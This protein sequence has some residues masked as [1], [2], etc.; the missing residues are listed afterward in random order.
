MDGLVRGTVAFVLTIAA[1]VIARMIVLS[2]AAIVSVTPFNGAIGAAPDEHVSITFANPM[3]R[4]SL[5]NSTCQL[6]MENGQVVP[7][8]VS[9]NAI[10]QTV[11][12]DATQ[13]LQYGAM[14]AVRVVGGGE[15]VKSKYF[16]RELGGDYTFGF[17]TAASPLSGP[18]GPI[19]VIGNSANPFSTYVPEI[20]R[21]EGLNEFGTADSWAITPELLSKYKLV[22]IGDTGINAEQV[23][24]LRGFAL[25]GGKLI[26]LRP[27]QRLAS[28]LGLEPGGEPI[29]DGYLKIDHNTPVGVGLTNTTIQYHGAADLYSLNGATALAWIYSSSQ[30]ATNWPA[31]TI[32]N[33]GTHGGE[34]A[35]FTFDLARAIVYTR[36]G[37]PAWSGVHRDDQKVGRS[38]DQLL[39]PAKPPWV[40]LAK[41]AVPQADEQQSLFANLIEQMMLPDAPLPRFWYFPSG[42]KAMIIMTGDDHASGGTLGRWRNYLAQENC[43]GMPISA[44][45]YLFPSLSIRDKL[46]A[47]LAARGFE[48]ALHVDIVRGPIFGNSS[49]IPVDWNSYAELDEIYRHQLEIFDSEYPS[50]PSPIT[51]RTHGVVWSDF[52]SQPLVEFSHGIRLDA[53]YYYWPPTWVNDR[54]GMFTGSGLPMRFAT[55]DGKMIDVYQESTEMTDESRQSYPY[56]VDALLDLAT[57]PTE[58]YGAFAMNAHTDDVESEASDAAVDCARKHNVPVISAANLLN[59]E[60][61][62]GSSSFGRIKWDDKSGVL[63]FTI[64]LALHADGLEAMVPLFDAGGHPLTAILCNGHRV[65]FTVQLIRGIYWAEFPATTGNVVINYSRGAMTPNAI[66]ISRDGENLVA[67]FARPIDPSTI[68]FK[69]LDFNGR[70]VTGSI[71]CDTRT[72][73]LTPRDPL[74]GGFEY[75]AVASALA[76]DGQAAGPAYLEFTTPSDAIQPGTYSFCDHSKAPQCEETPDDISVEVG[77]QFTADVPGVITGIHFYKFSSNTGPH[78]GRIWTRDGKMLASATSASETDSGWQTITFAQPIPIQR[79]ASYVASY[80][81][82]HGHYAFTHDFFYS[83]GMDAGPIHALA[84]DAIGGGNGVFFQAGQRLF[85][86]YGH[87]S[88]FPNQTYR[89]SNFW[90]DVDFIPTGPP[91]AK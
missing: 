76:P 36:Q 9:Y 26:A 7:T 74:R 24:A 39:G 20:L 70:A 87:G 67:S 77:V 85:N 13:P 33:V 3:E 35:A 38:D 47:P 82:D 1:A 19:L 21:A 6:L 44:S 71:Q 60:D 2:P 75:M 16:H 40:D 73:T 56:F 15:G 84:N 59:F 61:G 22:I 68:S 91:S 46:L 52:A 10:S 88:N 62:R 48:A 42:A 49:D 45:S 65:D 64:T 14:Y 23:D 53:N 86:E 63:N 55:A 57:G 90:V 80:H 83:R 17:T 41:I 79:G 58:A 31:V 25:G 28:L 5:S 51:N 34:V 18:G 81:C 54:P 12:L 66:S 37:N 72:A 30:T 32:R 29:A 50:L 11:T 27:D 69:L 89:A 4:A 78:A 8:R 43:G